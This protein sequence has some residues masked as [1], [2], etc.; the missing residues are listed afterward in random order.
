MSAFE[1]AGEDAAFLERQL[2]TY[3][4]NK[5][6]LL[7]FIDEGIKLVRR[8]TGKNRLSVFDAFSG[9]G[10][11]ARFCKR[12]A[13]RLVA[14]DLETYS[15]VI[16]SC[17]LANR[18]EVSLELIRELHRELVS[19]LEDGNLREGIITR[20]YSPVDESNIRIGERVFYSARNAR[21]IDTARLQ[22]DFL[23]LTL[24]KFFL[25]PLLSEA[26]KHVN[27][28]GVFKGFYKDSTTGI[29]RFGGRRKQALSRI[30][31]EIHL[32][33]P[34]LSNFESEVELHQEDANSLAGK[35]KD[36]DLSY[37]DP[38]YNQH[39][40]GSNYFML[41]LIVSNQNPSR[42]SKISGIPANWKRS[43]YNKKAKS[44]Q[45]LEDLISTLDSK[46]VLLSFNSEGFIKPDEMNKLLSRYGKLDVIETRYNAFRASRNLSSRDI[47]VKEY[48]YLLE[49]S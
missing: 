40:Y 4:G 48:L 8:R 41:N 36:I 16:N 17:Y 6:S 26:S 47:H 25:A 24:R 21:Y 10:I 14:N 39:P 11:V 27:T 20:L 33:L 22:I 43:L 3:L 44:Y 46:F 38:P 9:S 2:I 5:R 42:I 28:A 45:V 7:G 29:G 1:T 15:R 49:K 12:Y 32:P 31:G 35:I 18:S 30:L 37:I 13:A 23:P 19:K 34:I